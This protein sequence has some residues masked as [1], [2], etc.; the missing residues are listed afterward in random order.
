MQ[1]K[2]KNFNKDIFIIFGGPSVPDNIAG[3]A[4]K[5]LRENN[6]INVIVHQEGGKNCAS[7]IRGVSKE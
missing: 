7:V 1:K 6:F 3:K 2:L 4:E 5:F